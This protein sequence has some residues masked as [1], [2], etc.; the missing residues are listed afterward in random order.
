MLDISEKVVTESSIGAP[1][2]GK[3]FGPGRLV[4]VF[5]QDEGLPAY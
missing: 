5:E 4:K 1:R 3:G 2:V